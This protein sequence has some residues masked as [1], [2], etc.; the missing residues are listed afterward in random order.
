MNSPMNSP[1]DGPTGSPRPAPDLDRLEG[2]IR[3]SRARIDDT[4]GAL[5]DRVARFSPRSL[6][7]QTM[8]QTYTPTDHADYGQPAAQSAATAH[9]RSSV[10]GSMTG[11]PIP[12]ALVGIGLGWLALSGSGYDRR[13]AR[14]RVLSRMRHRAGDAADYARDTLSSATDSVRQAAGSAYDS[15]SQAVGSAY[16]TAANAASNAV[17][18]A[19]GAVS[20]ASERLSSRVSEH[21]SGWSGATPDLHLRERLGH[22]STGFW[23]LVEDH[24]IVAGTMGVALGAAIGAALPATRYENRWV[25]DY[26]DEATERAKSLAMDALDRGTRAAQAAVQTAKEEVTEAV[27]AVGEAARDEARKPA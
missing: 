10:L 1:T 22:V 14:S 16:D 20:G 27:S 8:K 23:D 18:S 7:E 4:V 5:R 12:L 9:P 6:M 13:I 24:P 21:T 19:S 25:G 3:A 15:A 17:G 11:N 26:A 2:E